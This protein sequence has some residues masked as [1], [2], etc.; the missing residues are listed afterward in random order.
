V[1]RVERRNDKRLLRTDH[2]QLQRFDG[3]LRSVNDSCERHS[4]IDVLL[5]D[6]NEHD[7]FVSDDDLLA[8]GDH[9]AIDDDQHD[10][11]LPNAGIR[12]AGHVGRYARP[13]AGHFID[14]YHNAVA[15]GQYAE[16]HRNQETGGPVE[17]FADA[18]PGQAN[19]RRAAARACREG[20]L[21]QHSAIARAEW[22]DG[23]HPGHAAVVVHA[24][25]LA[26]GERQHTGG[27]AGRSCR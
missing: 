5:A 25:R 13:G 2:E 22:Q 15:A 24:G 21:D 27:S 7:L 4:D 17:R 19:S 23:Q 12:D 6:A 9:V 3:L 10:G 16:S 26:Q 8:A 11:Q 20:Q 18:G 1:R 14:D